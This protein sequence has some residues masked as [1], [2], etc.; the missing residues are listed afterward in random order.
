MR[1][2]TVFPIDD[3]SQDRRPRAAR[4]RS[5]RSL[6]FDATQA[7]RSAS[8]QRSADEH[9][10]ARRRGRML[11]RALECDG[12][13]GIEM[14]ALDK[15]PRH[16]AMSRRAC[17]MALHS[18][19]HGRR[20]RRA[21]ALSDDF[22]IFTQPA[23]ARRYGWSCGASRSNHLRSLRIWRVC[24]PKQA[25][26]FRAMTGKRGT[27]SA[28]VLSA[29]G[30]G[31]GV[32]AHLTHVP[33]G[34]VFAARLRRERSAI[35]RR[36]TRRSHGRAAPP[37]RGQARRFRPARHFARRRQHRRR[38]EGAAEPWQEPRFYNGTVG[39][40]VRKVQEMAFP[41]PSARC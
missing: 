9:R 32:D 19:H 13:A 5:A 39:T 35:S 23:R 30:L 24:L 26:L 33:R 7:A 11:L 3:A 6:E 12:T 41:W 21:V 10:E 16:R 14:I 18:G 25:S 8:R 28:H 27:G 37:W 31:H 38:V 34:T 17:A 4:P 22:Q 36:A 29:D 15:R 40:R 1:P 2:Q 20:P